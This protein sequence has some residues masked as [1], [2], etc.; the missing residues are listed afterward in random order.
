MKHQEHLIPHWQLGGPWILGLIYV[1]CLSFYPSEW[2]AFFQRWCWRSGESGMLGFLLWLYEHFWLEL[3]CLLCLC[4]GR[5]I[6]PSLCAHLF[7]LSDSRSPWAYDLR[8]LSRNSFVYKSSFW[9]SVPICALA[10]PTDV[11]QEFLSCFQD[12]PNF[13]LF[14][15]IN[16]TFWCS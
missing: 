13:C 9:S 6:A 11:R 1:Y 3:W 5:G 16:H 14:Q 10:P 4:G 12:N 8:I 2:F 15:E 7:I